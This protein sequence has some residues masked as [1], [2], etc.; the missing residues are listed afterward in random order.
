MILTVALICWV[1]VRPA[2]GLGNRRIRFELPRADAQTVQAQPMPDP[3]RVRSQVERTRELL[4]RAR[5]RI[6]ACAEDRARAMLLGA[7]ELQGR[8]EL[9]LEEQRT[10]AA[11]R[12]TM[13]ARDRGWR[14]LRLCNVHE[15]LGAN[16]ERA[17]RRTGEVLERAQQVVARRGDDRAQIA[18]HQAF[19]LQQRAAV[20]FH[21]GH[22]DA[23]L[24]LT[25]SARTSA[26]RAIRLSGGRL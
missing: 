3:D 4:D 22:E 15:D 9:A 12:L 2:F 11:L 13:S 5:D 21:L 8:A 16:A 23:A 20:E 6:E 26:Y 17:M 18:L 10:L 14:A 19:D 25:Q 24:R 7:I 1:S